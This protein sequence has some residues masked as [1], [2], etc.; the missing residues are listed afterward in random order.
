MR[1]KRRSRLPLYNY[2]GE[3]GSLVISH[4]NA[5]FEML[6]FFTEKI[7]KIKHLL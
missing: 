2:T 6:N 7:F 3:M 5:F 1:F 4:I